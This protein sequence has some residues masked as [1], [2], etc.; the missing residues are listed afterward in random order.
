MGQPAVLVR[1]DVLD[2]GPQRVVRELVRTKVQMLRVVQ[3]GEELQEE[4][5]KDLGLSLSKTQQIVREVELGEGSAVR[6]DHTHG[7]ERGVG[8]LVVGQFKH[9]QLL[10]LRK[11]RYQLLHN[12]VGEVKVFE[13]YADNCISVECL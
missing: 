11:R 9:C 4:L 8:Q 10:V 5:V 12:E 3:L 1:E 6:E 7:L 2:E 13:D